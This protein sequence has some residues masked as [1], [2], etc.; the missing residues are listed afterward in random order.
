MTKTNSSAVH[1]A[2]TGA[3]LEQAAKALRRGLQRLVVWK[4][5]AMALALAISILVL[6]WDAK[7]HSFE[8]KIV[9]SEFLTSVVVAVFL[10]LFYDVFIRKELSEQRK[11]EKLEIA[12]LS[13]TQFMQRVGLVSFDDEE[14]GRFVDL[15]ITNK[16]F[17]TALGKRIT[18]DPVAQA[19]VIDSYL[20]P[21]RTGLEIL[22]VEAFNR[23]SAQP[24][25]ER[26]YNWHCHKNFTLSGRNSFYRL[27]VTAD[28]DIANALCSPQTKCDF[29]LL[30]TQQVSR[31]VS[32]ITFE[33]H[34]WESG[35]RHALKTHARRRMLA[36]IVPSAKMLE[37]KVIITD[38]ILPEHV[39]SARCSVSFD[40]VLSLSDPYFFWSA[41]CFC[42][43]K[44]VVI[45]YSGIRD[46]VGGISTLTFMGCANATS[47]HDKEAG[48]VRVQ[49]DGLLTPGDAVLLV[50]RERSS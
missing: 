6:G 45:D 18:G 21:I 12:H 34:V 14:I 26:V 49:A 8:F 29:V 28:N 46:S 48:I 13:S 25:D 1:E 50:W 20:Q 22:D 3:P 43:V 39:E 9:T 31:T 32:S 10:A 41:D 44:S 36:D 15:N 38:Y 11:L 7:T 33:S 5:V 23:L 37:D 30:A 42:T 4:Y 2:E 27:A 16:R 40:H 47:H 24:G 19:N 35:Q 17:L